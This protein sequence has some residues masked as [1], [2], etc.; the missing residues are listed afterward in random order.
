MDCGFAG[1]FDS[2]IAVAV[3]PTL[4]RVATWTSDS[5]VT[6]RSPR[7]VGGAIVVET[8]IG[9]Q[10]GQSVQVA[11][12]EAP[13][14]LRV[15][16]PSLPPSGNAPV[17]VDGRSF[18]FFDASAVVTVGLS[19]C[20]STLYVSDTSIKCVAPNGL[21]GNLNISV[22]IRGQISTAINVFS[23]FPPIISDAFPRLMNTTGGT[24]T[25]IGQNFGYFS[26]NQRMFVGNT[27]CSS[28]ASSPWV[29][30]NWFSHAN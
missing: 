6:C 15:T 17:T 13:V 26:Q 30:G 3:G 23:Y 2:T 1:T 21:G 25:V 11:S 4:C 5:A 20:A 24:I 29:A 12:Y 27:A 16:P 18:G 22:Q 19:A 10:K 8:V 14:I 9:S 28:A 7:G